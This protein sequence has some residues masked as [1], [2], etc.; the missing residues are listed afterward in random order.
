M[1]KIALLLPIIVFGYFTAL[2][3]S[4]TLEDGKGSTV[5]SINSESM[6]S[7]SNPEKA[8]IEF[9]DDKLSISNTSGT[10]FLYLR[11]K[12]GRIYYAKTILDLK[13]INYDVF[14][15]H[16]VVYA[17]NNLDNNKGLPLVQLND[18]D[19]KAVVIVNKN[20]KRYF[21]PMMF[22]KFKVRP[23]HKFFEIF[24]ADPAKAYLLKS[25]LKRRSLT[26]RDE[27]MPIEGWNKKYRFF[28]T[29]NYYIKD[30]SGFYTKVKLGKGSIL[31]T[32]NDKPF[33]KK[34]K[35]Y[36]KSK[37]LKWRNPSDIQKILAYYYNLKQ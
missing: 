8:K 5:F 31:K 12:P 9:E 29:E 33:E 26:H 34:L 30:K 32:L 22:N 35:R 27:G 2:A 20:K 18:N 19:I 28:D 23:K 14:D 16:F 3:Q 25:I 37:K 36:A 6:F 17:P 24:T 7:I 4:G 10:P 1:K 11:M 21:I 13:K 15:D